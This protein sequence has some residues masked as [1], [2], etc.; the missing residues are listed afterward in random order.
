MSLW[1]ASELDS[2]IAA[3]KQT[4]LDLANHTQASGP[5][6]RSYTRAELPEVRKTIRFLQAEKQRLDHPSPAIVSGRVYRA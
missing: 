2:Q 5:D 1:T 3:W 6:G 4:L